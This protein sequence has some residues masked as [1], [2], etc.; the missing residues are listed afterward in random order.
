[1][2][3]SQLKQRWKKMK[4]KN[5]SPISISNSLRAIGFILPDLRP[6]NVRLEGFSKLLTNSSLN[7]LLSSSDISDISK[8]RLWDPIASIEYLGESNHPYLVKL[9][10]E[11]SCGKYANDVRSKNPDIFNG[12]C[13]RWMPVGELT[14]GKEIAVPINNGNGIEA[15]GKNQNS[16]KNNLDNSLVEYTLTSGCFLKCESSDHTGQLSDNPAARYGTSSGSTA[17]FLA[18]SKNLSNPV[19]GTILI[20]RDNTLMKELNSNIENPD[21]SNILSLCSSN[22][23]NKCAGANSFILSSKNRSN[24]L[25]CSSLPLE[26][27]VENNTLASTTSFNKNTVYLYLSDNPLLTNLPSFRA[28]FFDSLDLDAKYSMTTLCKPLD[29]LSSNSN[30]FNSTALCKNLSQFTPDSS[31]TLTISSGIFNT[32][33]SMLTN[34]NI[35][36]FSGILWDPIASIEY[37]GE[38][39]VYDVEIEGAHNFIGNGIFAHNTYADAGNLASFI[40]WNNSLVGWWRFNEGNGT[41]V[42]DYSGYGN[43]GA[44]ANFVNIN[45][46]L[47][48]NSSSGWTSGGKFGAGMVF[49]GVDDYII[50]SG[51]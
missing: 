20:L 28:C 29:L 51:G 33:Y 3:I 9:A 38:E 45:Q 39:Q 36:S 1:M 6:L 19:S 40:N 13:A 26:M 43:N 14:E 34:K 47:N 16:V 31:G 46:G 21:S 42:V 23:E 5:L 4:I 50:I 48:A 12:Y 2:I 41:N 27:T 24:I 35:N 37:L 18:L 8:A 10:D 17:N 30:T 32:S 25:L 15:I 49:D 22:S 7:S 11:E 44:A